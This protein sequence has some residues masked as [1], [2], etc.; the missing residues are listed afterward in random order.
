M[1]VTFVYYYSVQSPVFSFSQIFIFIFSTL[2]RAE[3]LFFFFI[4]SLRWTSF[5]SPHL[6]LSTHTAHRVVAHLPIFNFFFAWTLRLY[7]MPF[8]FNCCF[9]FSHKDE[10]KEI[11]NFAN[12]L[13]LEWNRVRVFKALCCC[14]RLPA[15]LQIR[16][17]RYDVTLPARQRQRFIL[18]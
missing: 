6:I 9:A 2:A 5:P 11:A 4:F 10:T 13:R 18:Y 14:C 16:F 17:S 8:F 3:P 7:V 1:R 12:S 15:C